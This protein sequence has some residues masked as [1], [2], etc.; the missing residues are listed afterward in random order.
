MGFEFRLV[1]NI[2][3]NGGSTASLGKPVFDHSHNKKFL[4]GLMEF[5]LF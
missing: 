4:L 2:S 3:K 1:L 5:P